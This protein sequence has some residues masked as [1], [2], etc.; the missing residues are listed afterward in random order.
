MPGVLPPQKEMR[1]FVSSIDKFS[2]IVLIIVIVFITVKKHFWINFMPTLH[3]RYWHRCFYCLRFL[4][5]VLNICLRCCEKITTLTTTD[6]MMR[7]MRVI[8]KGL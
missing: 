8:M 1:V 6:T 2:M 3:Q 5:K 7:H 4:T